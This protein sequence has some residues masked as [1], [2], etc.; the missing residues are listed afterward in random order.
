MASNRFGGE[1]D[2]GEPVQGVTK[3]EPL[4]PIELRVEARRLGTIDLA[5]T[6]N[7]EHDLRWYEVWRA[8]RG[9]D[10]WG[11]ERPIGRTD[12]PA[13][14]FSDAS[15]GCGQQVRYRLRARDR[16]D[17]VSDHSRPVESTGESVGL[18]FERSGAGQG[19]LH[20]DARRAEGWPRARVLEV[21]TVRPDREISRL[22][23]ASEADL[24]P[25]AP[26]RRTFALEL[27]RPAG[28]GPE[29]GD[30]PLQRCEISVEVR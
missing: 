4:P 18:R 10:G 1:S 21:R 22:E 12:A 3:A 15:V 26:G 6:A 19:R 8:E 2:P 25:V 7:V 28:D 23:R 14:R 13:T 11:E 29:P 27:S 17:L 24:G 30:P 16:D 20:W 9:G 5:W